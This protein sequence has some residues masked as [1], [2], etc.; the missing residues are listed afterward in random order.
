MPSINSVLLAGYCE[1]DP[2]VMGEQG[3]VIS[4][5]LRIHEQVRKRDGSSFVK[6]EYVTVKAFGEA[7]NYI[8][9]YVS[10]GTGVVVQGKIKTERWGNGEE[11]K[12][13]TLVVAERVQATGISEAEELMEMGVEPAEQGAVGGHERQQGPANDGAG[14]RD[15]GATQKAHEQV[16]AGEATAPESHSEGSGAAGSGAAHGEAVAAELEHSGV[17]MPPAGSAEFE[18]LKGI[19][20][21]PW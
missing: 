20:G 9:V 2:R 3:N 19:Q 10:D 1:G 14:A 11:R 4:L 12:K 15:D 7:A 13:E 21:V 6:T 5:R 18:K 8:G 16:H 17:E